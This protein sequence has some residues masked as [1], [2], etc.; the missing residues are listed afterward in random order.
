MA[1]S[2]V[3]LSAMVVSIV[4]LFG[5]GLSVTVFFI[6]GNFSMVFSIVGL[7]DIDSPL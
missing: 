2:L 3:G 5:Y 6:V 4:E 1:F 7:S